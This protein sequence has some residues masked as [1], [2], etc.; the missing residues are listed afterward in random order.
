[1]KSFRDKEV[2]ITGAGSG[3]GRATALAFAAEG[4]RLWLADMNEQSVSETAVAARELGA[5]ART[6]HCD[7]A[8]VDSVQAMADQVHA[9]IDALDI[10]MNNA[11]IA[12]GGRFLDTSLA[13][14]RKVLDINLMGVV[15][16]CHAFLPRMVERK[17]G[18]HV[19]NT[20]SA[21][22]FVA[23][24][25]LPVYCASKFAVRGF[26][27]ALRADM[28][29][30]GIGVSAICPGVINTPI[31]ANAIMEGRLGQGQR[32]AKVVGFYDKRNYGPERV[33]KA[34]LTAVRRNI[35]VLPVS[36][37]AWG[38]YWAKRFA[39]GA[40]QKVTSLELPFLK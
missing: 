40:V 2:L 16:G 12:S 39:P 31:V 20:A 28:S 8:D 21:A 26:T 36:P 13:T 33:A 22:A 9:E 3:I 38:M 18:G 5:V 27:E 37:E 23:A 11:G 32:Q 14:W 15:H 19:L 17:R 25:D 30:H 6:L 35:G 7:V 1:M 4:A 34:V 24:P 10:L 29:Q